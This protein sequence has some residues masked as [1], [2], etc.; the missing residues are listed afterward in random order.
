MRARPSGDVDGDL[1]PRCGLL[2]AA[3]AEQ[4]EHTYLF[5]LDRHG[6][7]KAGSPYLLDEFGSGGRGAAIADL[8]Q[9]GHNEIVIAS[10]R[11]NCGC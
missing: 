11:R 1:E 2:C 3:G 10:E 7:P 4:A 5:I 6:V 9:D 8:D